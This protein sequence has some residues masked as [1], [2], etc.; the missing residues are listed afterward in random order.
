MSFESTLF[1]LWKTDNLLKYKAG[2]IENLVQVVQVR[3]K[4]KH[5]WLSILLPFYHFIKYAAMV[6]ESFES[7]STSSGR[8]KPNF[9]EIF[10]R[11]V[12]YGNSH[13]S[14]HLCNLCNSIFVGKKTLYKCTCTLDY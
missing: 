8:N 9:L 14:C 4:A 3:W 12:T 10:V 6:E 5:E 2:T 11:G 7:V 1:C 13:S